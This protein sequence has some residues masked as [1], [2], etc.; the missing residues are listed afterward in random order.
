MT[1]AEIRTLVHRA[2]GRVAPEADLSK[3]AGD[4]D[5]RDELDIDSMDFV[6]FITELHQEL[7]IDI[8]EREYSELSTV[9]GAVRYLSRRLERQPVARA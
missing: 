1:P 9:D 3:V 5:I 6:N 7:S 8:P 2:I 4:V